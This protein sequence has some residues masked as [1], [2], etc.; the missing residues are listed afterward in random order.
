MQNNPKA[1]DRAALHQFGI[2]KANS[3]LI[4]WEKAGIFPRRF[5]IGGCVFWDQNSVLARLAAEAGQ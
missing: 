5:R 3:T 2:R 1:L 4:R